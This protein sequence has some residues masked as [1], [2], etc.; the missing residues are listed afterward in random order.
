MARAAGYLMQAQM[1]CGT[2][3][4]TTMTYGAI[5]ALRRDAGLARDWV[6]RLLTRDYDPRDIPIEPKHGGLI[7]MGMT[8]KQ[9]GSD[10]RANTT[11]AERTADGP[12]GSTATSGSSRRPQCDAHLVLAQTGGRPVVLLHAAPSAGRHAATASSSND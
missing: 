5:A 6:P 4:P 7:G 11:R 12:T 3:C 9:G 10:V 1:E 8:E 2:L